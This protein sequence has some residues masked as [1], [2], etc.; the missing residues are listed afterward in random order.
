MMILIIS[1]IV[2][3]IL[4]PSD[5]YFLFAEEWGYH[6][7]ALAHSSSCF[8]WK[9]RI[10]RNW[11]SNLAYMFNVYK[12]QLSRQTGS[13]NLTGPKMLSTDLIFGHKLHI[14]TP[15]RGKRFWTHQIPT[16]CLPTLLVFIHIE[17]I[18]SF[19][20]TFFSATIDGRDLIFGHKL[21]I[22]WSLWPIIRLLPSIVAEKN[23]IKNGHIQNVC[24]MCI[25]INKVGIFNR[26]FL[27]NYWW[28]KSD[29]WSQ[30]SYRYPISWEAFLDPSDSYF[31][32]ADFVDFYR[33]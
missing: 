17:H 24:S 29:Y 20:V 3:S 30:A 5:S 18:C 11:S 1:H 23:A 4:D 12:N 22:I 28:Q 25:K 10:L 21:H 6:K 13:R 27:S 9:I 14:G 2:E 15:Y 32:F 16:S 7:W 8:I 19:F 33:K 31:L 26:I